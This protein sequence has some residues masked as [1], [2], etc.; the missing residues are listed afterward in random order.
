M[1]VYCPQCRLLFDGDPAEC[2]ACGDVTVSDPRDAEIATLRAA[3]ATAERPR[4]EA[5]REC[6]A[7][8]RDHDLDVAGSYG[9]GLCDAARRIR[10]KL[11]GM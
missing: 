10:A 5:L 3:L 4:D 8:E 1:S 11:E 9:H 7:I 2:G 6:E